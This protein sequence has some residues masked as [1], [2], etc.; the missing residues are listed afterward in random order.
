MSLKLD[1][2]I[3]PLDKIIQT[4]I[5]STL[6]THTCSS[7][8]TLIIH[9]LSF[10]KTL[11]CKSHIS[12]PAKLTSKKLGVLCHLHQIFFKSF[13][14]YWLPS[15]YCMLHLFVSSTIIFMLTA[16]LNLLTTCL[17]SSHAAHDFLS[18]LIYLMQKLTIIFTLSSLLM[19]NS[20]TL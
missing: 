18:A 16:L 3:Y 5:P 10:T 2:F 4:T 15:S 20:G 9:G 6:M 11:N 19:A 12:S 13:T 8:P 17:P 14:S 1:F 7:S